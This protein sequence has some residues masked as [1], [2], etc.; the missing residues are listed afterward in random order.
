MSRFTSKL[1]YD[2]PFQYVLFVS[3]VCHITVHS[4][5]ARVHFDVA[6]VLTCLILLY[7]RDHVNVHIITLF[8]FELGSCVI[9]IMLKH[10][11]HFDHVYT[12]PN[13][14]LF[15]ICVTLV[16]LQLPEGSI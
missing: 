11:I 15:L 16:S 12:C 13:C 4:N 8:L 1:C 14:L 5:P 2:L 7:G 6:T 3:I 9:C 10:D